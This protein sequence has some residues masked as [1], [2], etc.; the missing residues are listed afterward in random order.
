MRHY[1]SAL[2]LPK[3]TVLAEQFNNSATVQPFTNLENSRLHTAL[4]FFPYYSLEASPV[5]RLLGN[6]PVIPLYLP[7]YPIRIE[8]FW[9]PYFFEENIH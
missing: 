6:H 2:K 5:I 7:P 9:E 4:S 8:T 1:Y 3:N